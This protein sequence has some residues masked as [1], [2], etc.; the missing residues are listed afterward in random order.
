MC[1]QNSSDSTRG[2]AIDANKHVEL[3]G[4]ETRTWCRQ[5][6]KPARKIGVAQREYDASDRVVL[7]TVRY[8]REQDGGVSW[9]EIGQELER[10]FRHTQWPVTATTIDGVVPMEVM[11]SSAIAVAER[12]RALQRVSELEQ[13][14]QAL[15]QQL[16]EAQKEWM[17]DEMKRA[18]ELYEEIGRLK[19]LLK[20]NGIEW[21]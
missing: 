3:L 14:L 15:R 11:T 5:T 13:E 18:G 19:G 7:N 12:D 4:D 17:R 1:R 20:Q 8:L 21:E 9:T 2:T 16:N 10:G 6:I